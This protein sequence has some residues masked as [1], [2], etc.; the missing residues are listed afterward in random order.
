LID[1][2][3]WW[4]VG[5]VNKNGEELPPAEI[6]RHDR[7]GDRIRAKYSSKFVVDIA[8]RKLFARETGKLIAV[9]LPWIKRLNIISDFVKKRIIISLQ[10]NN[11]K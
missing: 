10:S 2:R 8:G 4:L 9:P 11:I 6:F 5:G 1:N 3:H 7:G